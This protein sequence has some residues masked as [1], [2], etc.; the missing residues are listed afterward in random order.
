[1][2]NLT[3]KWSSAISLHPYMA[4]SGWMTI[5]RHWRL[6]KDTNSVSLFLQIWQHKMPTLNQR[7]GCF[8]IESRVEFFSQC[9]QDCPLPPPINRRGF[10]ALRE[11]KTGSKVSHKISLFPVSAT[12]S[13]SLRHCKLQATLPPAPPKEANTTTYRPPSSP[14]GSL[15]LLLPVYLS[16]LQ[17]FFFFLQQPTPATIPS[18]DAS[19]ATGRNTSSRPRPPRQATYSIPALHQPS[20]CYLLWSL[21]AEFILHA[22]TKIINFPP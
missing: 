9:R 8:P 4:R 1:M 11:Q 21:H 15:S 7:L 19:W 12:F 16:P 13:L 10:Q 20:P 17:T 6:P 5:H 18:S 2:T 22:A 14:W 3:C